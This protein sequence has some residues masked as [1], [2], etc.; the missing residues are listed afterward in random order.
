MLSFIYFKY[1]YLFSSISITLSA[2]QHIHTVQNV[3]LVFQ[4]YGDMEATMSAN[5][6]G[7]QARSQ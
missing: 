4:L 5:L 1:L 6:P 7:R 3:L 2:V